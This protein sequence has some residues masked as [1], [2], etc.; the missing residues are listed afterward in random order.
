MENSPVF[1]P[2][3][4]EYFSMEFPKAPKAL[5]SIHTF[6]SFWK[7]PKWNI[8]APMEIL[9]PKLNMLKQW[10]SRLTAH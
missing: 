2:Q 5:A 3:E 7:I 9:K 4:D 1:L 8:L 10:L 6:H